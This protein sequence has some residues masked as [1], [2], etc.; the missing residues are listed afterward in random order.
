[1]NIREMI[2]E[3]K[4][5]LSEQELARARLRLAEAEIKYAQAAESRK[6]TQEWLDRTYNI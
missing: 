3:A 6:I 5:P 1:M 2:E 4:K